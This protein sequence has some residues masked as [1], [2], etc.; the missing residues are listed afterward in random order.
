[1]DTSSS[2][3]LDTQRLGRDLAALS[4][5]LVDAPITQKALHAIDTGGATL[6]VGA[7]DPAAVRKVRPVLEDMSSHVFLMG[8][9]GAGHTMKTLNNYVSVGSIIALCDALVCAL[10]SLFFS[11]PWAEEKQM[12]VTGQKLGLDPQTM[13]DAMNV[14][15]GINFSTAYSMKTLK[16]FDSGYQLDLLIKDIKIAQDVIAQAGFD[17]KLPGLARAYLEEALPLVEKGAC[18]SECLRSWEKRAGV[19]IKKTEREA[20]FTPAQ[21]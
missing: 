15:T 7:D 9:L 21:V 5:A 18:H 14:G 16:S 12:Q 11:S 10:S 3:P 1:M 2:S 4:L 20:S 6:M 13:I 8:P 17:T 19:E